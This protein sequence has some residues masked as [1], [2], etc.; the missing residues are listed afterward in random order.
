[1]LSRSYT[2]QETQLICSALAGMTCKHPVDTPRNQ[3]MK[4]I[5]KLKVNRPSPAT[6]DCQ[7]FIF[8]PS[9]IVNSS[10]TASVFSSNREAPPPW[11]KSRKGEQRTAQQH[12]YNE[13]S[14]V[15]A[16]ACMTQQCRPCRHFK[17]FDP[18]R[19]RATW[20]M[21]ITMARPARAR[22]C[23]HLSRSRRGC[24]LADRG[25]PPAPSPPPPSLQALTQKSIG[26]WAGSLIRK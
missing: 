20:L 14:L 15:A 16:V 18:S 21:Q 23:S 11:N 3:T 24:N 8:P 17:H 1:M 7:R 6:T 9:K 5:N 10:Q 25:R 26:K 22:S 13:Y 2:F 4:I 12:R 19:C